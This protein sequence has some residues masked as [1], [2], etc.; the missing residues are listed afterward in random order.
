MMCSLDEAEETQSRTVSILNVEATLKDG[1]E[2]PRFVEIEF[3]PATIIEEPPERPVQQQKGKANEPKRSSS[4]FFDRDWLSSVSGSKENDDSAD[5][6]SVSSASYY[7]PTDFKTSYWLK[8]V[9]AQTFGLAAIAMAAVITHPILLA[10]ALTAF[11]TATAV[12]AAYDFVVE[13]SL[14]KWLCM[15]STANADEDEQQKLLFEKELAEKEHDDE[16]TEE[17]SHSADSAQ[18]IE[19]PTFP[20]HKH[21]HQTSESSLFTFDADFPAKSLHNYY[22]LLENSIVNDRE[23]VG[24]NVIQFFQVFYADHAPYNFMEY[25]K[26]RGDIDI[27]YGAW[28][29]L[30]QGGPLSM[31]P[32]APPDFPRDIEYHAYKGRSLSFKAKTNSFFG[33][34]YA[35]TT[36]T[37]RI[38]I[39]SKKLAI[40]ESKT[41]LSDI[42]FC[43]RFFVMERWTIAA[44]KVNHRYK[45]Q[46]S[47]TCQAILT[48]QCPFDKQIRARSKQ[49]V[50]DVAKAWC[51]MAKEA[52]KLTEQ[53]KLDRL[54]QMHNDDDTIHNENEGNSKPVKQETFT[55]EGIEVQHSH[56]RRGSFI[57]D[58]EKNNGIC[59][60]RSDSEPC[61]QQTSSRSSFHGFKCSLSQILYP[62]RRAALN[63]GQ[64]E[65]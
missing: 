30:S 33:P 57:V 63:K 39:V 52:L 11:G 38:L 47:A 42:P 5:V 46:V 21:A 41:V 34:P 8:A 1:Q 51:A 15:S 61:G 3:D 7:D 26:K 10:G 59:L 31:H 55:N 9:D 27:K 40:I 23:F 16:G 58:E 65:I 29:D 18:Q 35:S 36:K 13:G 24:L 64:A 50:T 43:D 32:E 54:R 62:R 49:T 2:E 53:A 20:T 25:Q 48:K 17:S 60:L 56:D 22:P 37:Q 6:A 28:E 4:F 19:E 12:G 44:A 14:G 45:A